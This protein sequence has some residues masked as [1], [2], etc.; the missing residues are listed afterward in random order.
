MLGDPSSISGSIY[1]VIKKKKK[2]RKKER[3]NGIKR[4]GWKGREGEG[5]VG[6]DGQSGDTRTLQG[7]IRNALIPDHGPSQLGLQVSW[8]SP[9]RV[10][11]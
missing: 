9:W 5:N 4:R 6:F 8:W 11:G 3:K 7:H 10:S 2:E 1:M